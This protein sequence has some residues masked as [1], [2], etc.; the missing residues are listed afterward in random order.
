MIVAKPEMFPRY[1]EKH[2]FTVLRRFP[3]SVVYEARAGSVYVVAVARSSRS[4][5]YWQERS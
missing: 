2:Q 5:G 1:D 3:Y 4:R